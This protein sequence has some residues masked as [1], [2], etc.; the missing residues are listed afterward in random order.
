MLVFASM[1]LSM[2]RLASLMSTINDDSG[3]GTDADR[4]DADVVRGTDNNCVD[5]D[6]DVVCIVFKF[7]V[8]VDRSIDFIVYTVE[9]V[10]IVQCNYCLC[11]CYRCCC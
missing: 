3:G 10:D 6:I 5:A 4:V 1:L 8:V 9:I 2:A 11:H 7:V